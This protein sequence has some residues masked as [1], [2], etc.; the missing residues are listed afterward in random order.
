M[1]FSELEGEVA[2]DNLVAAFGGVFF[3]AFDAAGE[4]AEEGLFLFEDDALYEFLL[5]LQFGEL[6]SELADEGGDEGVQEGFGE[7]EEGVAVADGAAQ[8]AA[9]DVAG[10]DVGRQLAVGDGEADGAQVVG[11]DSHGD[12]GILVLA[13]DFAAF[14][15][16]LLDEGLEDVGVVV[17]AFALHDHAE[18][19]EAHAGVDVLGCQ[20]LEAAV[21][22]AVELHEHEVPYLDHLR[23]VFVDEVLSGHFGFLFG[24]AD[25]DVYLRAGAAGALVSHLPEVVFFRATQ[26]AVFADV[27]LPEVVGFGVHAE[28]L[29][30]VAAEDGDV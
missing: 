13:V 4:G 8:Y 24:R 25:V 19:L 16:Y 5:L 10:L 14:A 20:R 30:L 7:A 1:P 11:A 12:V 2:V 21:G 9:Y 27:G 22:L 18:A 23:V 29:F 3:E 6:V 28:T 17:G 26:Y 15:G